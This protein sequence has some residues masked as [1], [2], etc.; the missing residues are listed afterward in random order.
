MTCEIRI[1]KDISSKVLPEIGR[2]SFCS[3]DTLYISFS[4]LGRRTLRTL[5]SRP[6]SNAT[7]SQ[8]IIVAIYQTQYCLSYTLPEQYKYWLFSKGL[9]FKE[10]LLLNRGPYSICN[11][12]LSWGGARNFLSEAAAGPASFREMMME[13]PL[14]PWKSEEPSTLP[15]SS[16]KGFLCVQVVAPK[17]HIYVE[18][19]GLQT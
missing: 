19:E 8:Q 11:K 6:L 16:L 4:R 9:F 3:L 10:A 17:R 12:S 13:K 15:P 1:D 18:K 7:L 5:G 2:D 14:C